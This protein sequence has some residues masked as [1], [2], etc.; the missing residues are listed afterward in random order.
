MNDIPK[1]IKANAVMTRTGVD[2]TDVIDLK[3]K[4]GALAFE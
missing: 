4:D 3:Y 2:E 1:E